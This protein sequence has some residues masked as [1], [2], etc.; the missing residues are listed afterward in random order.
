ML[1]SLSVG[2]FADVG[3]EIVGK[4]ELMKIIKTIS[5]IIFNLFFDFLLNSNY[6]ISNNN[7]NQLIN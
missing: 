2:K 5:W 1:D 3:V 4:D 6:F 7:F